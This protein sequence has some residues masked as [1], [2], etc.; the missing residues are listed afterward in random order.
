[1]ICHLCG[2]RVPGKQGQR[3]CPHCSALN[4]L[5]AGLRRLIRS[6]F[7]TDMPG[8]MRTIGSM[9][10]AGYRDEAIYNA[11]GI[12]RQA[13]W[14]FVKRHGLSEFEKKCRDSPDLTREELEDIILD[15]VESLVK[16][17]AIEF[18]GRRLGGTKSMPELRSE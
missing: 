17:K 12:S 7:S 10:A 4:N 16:K 1:M 18:E 2:C 13:Y 15:H 9:A 11:L 6:I 8:R 14:E 3:Y 5:T